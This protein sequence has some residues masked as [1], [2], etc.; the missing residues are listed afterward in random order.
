M[1][2]NNS[3]KSTMFLWH[4]NHQHISESLGHQNCLLTA[5]PHDLHKLCDLIQFNGS[6]HHLHAEA[7]P[8]SISISETVSLRHI[9]DSYIYIQLPSWCLYFVPHSYFILIMFKTKLMIF[10]P[11]Y[12]SFSGF[13]VLVTGAHQPPSCSKLKPENYLNSL[14]YFSPKMQ[15]IASKTSLEPAFSSSA[16]SPL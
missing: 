9:C 16:P 11:K 5:C 14:V 3:T 7:S 1:S 6:K 4:P 12:L 8:G 10:L 13:L 15:P 2:C